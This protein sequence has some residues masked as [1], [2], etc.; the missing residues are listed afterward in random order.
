MANWTT[1]DI[2][3]LHGRRAVVTG[4]NSGLGYE[5]ALALAG[6]G[7]SVVVACRDATKGTEAVDRIRWAHP[8]AD[9]VL[10]S[11]D[12]A[13]LASVRAFAE[14]LCGTDGVDIL[15]NN[16]GVMAIPRRVSAD[17]YEMQFATNHLGHFALTGLLLP[18]LLAKQP[19]RVVTVSSGAAQIGHIAFGDLQGEHRYFRWAAY[20][21]SKLANL[22]FAF[23]L[24][25]RARA[26][27][28]GIVS[29]AAHPGYAATNLQ[30][31]GPTMEGSSATQRFFEMGNRYFA[32]SAAEGALPQLRAA[33]DDAVVG[34]QYYGPNG[35]AGMRGA[36][37]IVRPPFQARS[38]D[39][40]RR[41]WAESERLTGVRF[42]DG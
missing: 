16:A 42:L 9:V 29:V 41:L 5:T 37:V 40:A 12:M 34:G 1:S 4:A 26:A 32:Q 39:T 28:L 6:A 22:L 31:V 11:L 19:A 20:G 2:P 33:T 17:G 27:D 3:D 38:T 14:R 35:M 15:V 36:P 24:D 13:D 10:E 18:A 8:K 21:Q 30:S 7:A 25:R 23:E